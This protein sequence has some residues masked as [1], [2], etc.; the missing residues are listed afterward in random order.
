MSGLGSGIKELIKQNEKHSNYFVIPQHPLTQLGATALAQNKVKL[1]SWRLHRPHTDDIIWSY[2]FI[3]FRLH[4]YTL[5]S[6]SNTHL[7]KFFPRLFQAVSQSQRE[8]LHSLPEMMQ[9]GPWPTKGSHFPEGSGMDC[10]PGARKWFM[11]VGEGKTHWLR[12]TWK[13]S[14]YPQ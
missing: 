11:V 7:R 12:S 14:Y 3:Y 8:T 5:Y 13:C 6:Y 2:S 9:L 4:A 1:P 10:S